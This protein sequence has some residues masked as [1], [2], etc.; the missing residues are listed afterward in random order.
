[1]PHLGNKPVRDKIGLG[2]KGNR[3]TTS[4][5]RFPK[6]AP[7]DVLGKS[8]NIMSFSNIEC[9]LTTSL[10]PP[11]QSINSTIRHQQTPI[12][13]ASALVACSAAHSTQ[14][15]T[16]PDEKV[17]LASIVRPNS[18]NSFPFDPADQGLRK[19]V[20]DSRFGCD[21]SLGILL[22]NIISINFSVRQPT[23]E[24]VPS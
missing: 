16:K 15:N 14:A 12:F 2:I 18:T 3:T 9:V 22:A 5:A 7:N 23:L 17:W 6:N 1:M 20:E 21:S 19:V 8:M 13:Y 24:V 10:R 11:S 4:D